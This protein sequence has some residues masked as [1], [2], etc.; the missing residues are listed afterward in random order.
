MN[1]KNLTKKSPGLDP[2]YI[3]T[4]SKNSVKT[5]ST[6]GILD[7]GTGDKP[8]LARCTG[9]R[10]STQS[11]VRTRL[12]LSQSYW[13]R[14]YKIYIYIYRGDRTQEIT[15]KFI[16]NR[17]YFFLNLQEVKI[18]MFYYLWKACEIYKRYKKIQKHNGPSNIID[19][20]YWLRICYHRTHVQ[21]FYFQY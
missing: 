13:S 21:K 15:K 19:Q 12:P 11:C 10:T 20:I 6:Y 14:I 7:V 16:W 1:K 5:S 18:L 17:I 8:Y 4:Y 9:C 2:F 3:I